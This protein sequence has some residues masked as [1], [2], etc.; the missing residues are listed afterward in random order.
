MNRSIKMIVLGVA[1]LGIA[2]VGTA[3]LAKNFGSAK[4]A[5]FDTS[6]VN[7]GTKKPD[8]GKLYNRGTTTRGMGF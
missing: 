6:I 1:A 2:G 5:G 4:V 3:S 7:N 8:S